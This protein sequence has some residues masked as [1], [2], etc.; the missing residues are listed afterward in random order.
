M[1]AVAARLSGRKALI[2]G[3]G[4]GIGR[5]IAH[6]FAG[7]GADVALLARNEAELQR[8]V[9]EVERLNRKAIAIVCDVSDKS[10]VAAAV[11]HANATLGTIDILVNSAGIG[12]SHKFIDHDDQLWERILAVNLTGVYQVTKNV[13]PGMVQ[14]KWGRIINL[15]SFAG[16]TGAKYMAAYTASKHGVI[17][18]TRALAMEFVTDGVTVNAI[19]PA[20]VDTPMA[21]AAIT[22]IARRTGRTEADARRALED[23]S[24]Q[25]RLIAPEEIATVAVFLASD[26]AKGITAQAINVDG[27]A[28][29]Y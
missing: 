21:D 17:G 2:T 10:Q 18:L 14:R 9:S 6:A 29:M 28:M 5:A 23:V 22:N 3:G 7:E 12:Q 19:C 25:K 15:A 1:N 13:V 4:R 26:L 27:G 8:V 16:K 20:Y 11:A 24:P